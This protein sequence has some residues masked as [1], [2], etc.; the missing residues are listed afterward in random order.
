MRFTI[1]S[2]VALVRR[3]AIFAIS[4]ISKGAMIVGVGDM[5]TADQVGEA[6]VGAWP[7][8]AFIGGLLFPV[9]G[10]S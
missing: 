2:F 7:V 3:E 6:I 1:Q 8:I 10:P 4:E 5:A 9:A